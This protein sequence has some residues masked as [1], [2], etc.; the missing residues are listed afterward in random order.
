MRRGGWHP[1]VLE[2]TQILPAVKRTRVL[3]PERKKTSL[4]ALM[5][6]IF[7]FHEIGYVKDDDRGTNSTPAI[8]E[9]AG[10]PNTEEGNKKEPSSAAP[11]TLIDGW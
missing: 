2:L 4:P 1:E 11:S 3:I 7:E 5:V 6:V 8:A 9:G 10:R